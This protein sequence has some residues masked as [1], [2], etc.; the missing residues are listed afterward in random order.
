MARSMRMRRGANARVHV[1]LVKAHYKN[2]AQQLAQ[3]IKIAR[4][5]SRKIYFENRKMK[6]FASLFVA[7]ALAETDAQTRIAVIREQITVSEG[8]P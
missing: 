3:V 7:A 5:K 2:P 6:F 1:S 4:S 8:Y